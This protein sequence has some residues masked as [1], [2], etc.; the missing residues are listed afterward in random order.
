MKNE[1]VYQKINELNLTEPFFEVNYPE[2]YSQCGEDLIIECLLR[3]YAT[4]NELDM[5][6]F[7]YLEIGANH[8]IATSATYLL[9]KK[10]G[11]NGVLID[12]NP[13]LIDELKKIRKNDKIIN[14]AITNQ[15]VN[16]ITLHVPSASE[17]ATVS[18]NFLDYWKGKGAND[19]NLLQVKC[20]RINDILKTEFP[21]RVPEYI[22][23]DVEG[24]DLDI[25]HDIDFKIF[26][27]YI[28]SVEPS[29][30][31]IPYTSVKMIEFLAQNGY[32]LIART[33]VNL[34]FVD[35]KIA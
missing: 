10:Y 27:P 11:M 9:Y 24:I 22:S 25:L 12:A 14:V 15:D 2:L 23:I 20:S 33:D 30:H 8:P 21:D 31:F 6:N 4:I 18:D 17:L 19:I 16:E 32:Q 28:I 35:K 13:Y 3:A 26:R 5:H 7:K 34:I 1:Y 29:D